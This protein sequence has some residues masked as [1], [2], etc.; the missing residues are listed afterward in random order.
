MTG[1]SKGKAS[2]IDIAMPFKVARL[3]PDFAIAR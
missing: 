1:G 2:P 3:F